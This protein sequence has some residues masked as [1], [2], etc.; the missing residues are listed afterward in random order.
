MTVYVKKFRERL[1]P[2]AGISANDSGSFIRSGSIVTTISLFYLVLTILNLVIFWTATGSNQIRLIT[3]N[4][5][6]ESQNISYEILR[7]LQPLLS[8]KAWANQIRGTNVEAAALQVKEKVMGSNSENALPIRGFEIISSTNNVLFSTEQ[9]ARKSLPPEEFRN[10]LQAMQIREVKGQA[11]Y[12][13][14]DILKFR[15]IVYLPLTSA[16]VKDAVLIASISMQSVQ[17]E[18][19]SLITLAISMILIMLLVQGVFGFFI[20]RKFIR[21]VR[22]LAAGAVQVGEGNFETRISVPNRDEIGLLAHLFNRMI[23]SLKEKTTQLMDVISELTK[24]KKEMEIDLELGESIQKEM[25]PTQMTSSHVRASAYYKPLTKVS[26]DYYD[27]FVLP[28]GSIGIILCDAMGHGV[29]AAFMT[30]MAKIH[31]NSTAFKTMSTASVMLKVSKELEKILMGTMYLTGFYIIIEPDLKMRFTSAGHMPS[32]LM[33]KNSN[34]VEDFT[35]SGFFLG[36][37]SGIANEQDETQLE[38]GD[39]ILLFTDGISEARNTEDEMFGSERIKQFLLDT[40]DKD[41]DEVK[42]LLIQTIRDFA[43][44]FPIDDDITYLV[45]EVGAA[46][47]SADLWVTARRLFEENKLQ[48]TLQVLD[49]IPEDKYLPSMDIY[50]AYSHMRLSDFS[51]ARVIFENQLKNFDD[52]FE[53]HL[54]LGICY[55][56]ENKITESVDILKRSILLNPSSIFAHKCLMAA[57]HK[58]ESLLE[59][60]EILSRSLNYNVA[61]IEFFRFYQKTMEKLS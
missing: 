53:V 56:R 16:G 9:T 13:V 48:E 8:D 20:F 26:G 5:L 33:R 44:G 21:P 31:F 2:P 45:I 7:R 55:L 34:E 60:R 58:Q 30:I 4:A 17:D 19:D 3:R 43:N 32:L 6:L 29:P 24:R 41:I 25:L 51:A 1:R 47:T 38:P 18:I 61:N 28:D 49:S 15:V 22:T 46:E 10:V 27:F 37:A 36:I 59:F 40:R 50:R 12:G 23:G 11:F 57:M 54:N 39:R 35:T 14:P 52:D 42:D